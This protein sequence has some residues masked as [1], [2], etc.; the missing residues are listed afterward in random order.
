MRVVRHGLPLGAGQLSDFQPAR[1]EELFERRID[2]FLVVYTHA[3]EAFSILQPV[4]EDRK[5]RA[6]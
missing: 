1:A 5:Q 4:F 6:R 2:V 3:D